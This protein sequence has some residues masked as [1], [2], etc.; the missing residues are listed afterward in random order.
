MIFPRF[1]HWFYVATGMVSSHRK[2]SKG[3][4]YPLDSF[5]RIGESKQ[6]GASSGLRSSNKRSRGFQHLLSI[7]NDAAWGSDKAIVTVNKEGGTTT[8]K[9]KSSEASLDTV[10][11]ESGTD[12]ASNRNPQ[13]GRKGSH[14]PGLGAIVMTREW[15][16][17]ETWKHERT[18]SEHTCIGYKEPPGWR[19]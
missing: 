8:I 4:T 15:D 7:P 6:T 19:G 5:N 10:Y 16:I 11:E 17:S 3:A 13:S 18:N 14:D 12:F 1:K 2:S 9:D